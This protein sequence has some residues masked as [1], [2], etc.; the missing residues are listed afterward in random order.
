MTLKKNQTNNQYL[1]DFK[2]RIK[3]NILAEKNQ[4]V[5]GK[6]LIAN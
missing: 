1:F 3:K 4:I 2:N 5:D 6:K